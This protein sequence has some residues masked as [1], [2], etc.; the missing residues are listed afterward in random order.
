MI[1]D[2]Y[3]NKL[4]KYIGKWRCGARWK[5]KQSDEDGPSW[6]GVI[7]VNTWRRWVCGYGEMWCMSIANI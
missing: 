1:C 6:A 5:F 2:G 7:W 4:K 3:R